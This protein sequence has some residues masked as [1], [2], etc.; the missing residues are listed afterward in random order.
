[1]RQDVPRIVPPH[2]ST[3]DAAALAVPPVASTSSTIGR[4]RPAGRR[5]GAAPVWRSRTRARTPPRSSPT[6]ASRPC[7]RDEAGVEVVR[8]RG[9][10]DEAA[11][12]DPDDLVHR[13]A[14][15]VHDDQI[16]DRRH[17]IGVRE[18]RR[19]VLEDDAGLREVG[20]RPGSGALICSISTDRSAC[21]WPAASP[22][23]PPVP[24][25]V[26]RPCRCGPS[27]GRRPPRRS[28]CRGWRSW[29]PPPP[30]DHALPLGALLLQ[31]LEA[32]P[33]AFSTENNGAARKIDECTPIAVPMNIAN[34][35]SFG[36]RR[37]TAAATGSAGST[38]SDV[39]TDRISTW[40]SDR[41]IAPSA[42]S[43]AT[44]DVEVLLD[45][46]V[47]RDGVVQR[48]PQDREHGDHGLRV[49]SR[50]LSAY[51]PTVI[52]TSWIARRSRRS[53]S[54]ARTGSRCRA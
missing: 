15:E 29:R 40:F 1:M 18:D 25:A 7:D 13:P 32:D 39:F 24:A 43:R 31:L 2:R 49:T 50:P 38:T 26:V 46:V 47:G 20:L 35:K 4:A 19:D 17:R 51:T 12:L 36:S 45:L 9:R 37:R 10:E 5:R 16:D 22:L 30:G 41:S 52:V 23:R 6:G 27:R 28:R 21:A 8:D 3:S 34:A 48:E 42:P 53:P 14:A 11:R 33:R 54:S 44:S